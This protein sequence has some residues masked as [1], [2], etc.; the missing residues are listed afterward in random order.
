MG[1]NWKGWF[2]HN[3]TK[4]FSKIYTKTSFGGPCPYL[5]QT[6]LPIWLFF[7]SNTLWILLLN[8]LFPPFSWIFLLYLKRPWYS[9]VPHLSLYWLGKIFVPI[10]SLVCGKKKK[11]KSQLFDTWKVSEVQKWFPSSE[12]SC[13]TWGIWRYFF[14]FFF[15]SGGKRL[16]G[17]ELF[18]KR[19]RETAPPFPPPHTPP[20]PHCCACVFGRI[21]RQ[22]GGGGAKAASSSWLRP[23]HA[24]TRCGDSS[25]LYALSINTP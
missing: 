16:E 6:W 7:W 13:N 5:S 3:S 23:H 11:K 15:F 21:R 9:I 18:R 19:T 20:P 8:L 1:H 17:Q 10:S 22:H 24:A 14:F 4:K 12:M 25:R 2:Q